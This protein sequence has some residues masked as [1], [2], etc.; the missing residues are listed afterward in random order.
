MVA[1]FDSFQRGIAVTSTVPRSPFAG[2]APEF[3]VADL[4]RRN[5]AEHGQR[6]A[7][8]AGVTTVSYDELDERTNRV[9]QAL[10]EMEGTLHARIAV[11]DKNSPAVV[12]VLIGCAKAGL[13]MVPLNWRLSPTELLAVLQDCRATVL[14]ASDEFGAHLD[15]VTTVLPELRIVAVP[16]SGKTSAPGICVDYERWI[17][18]YEPIDPG[19]TGDADDP[20]LLLY[21]SGTTGTPKGVVGTNRNLAATSR[22]A[23]QWGVDSSTVMLVAMPL[24]HIGGLSLVFITLQHGGQMLMIREVKPVQLLDTMVASRVTNAFLVPSVIA[25]LIEVDDAANRDWSMLRSITYGASPITPA[26]LLRALKTF[27]RPL[28]QVYGMT[29]TH[30]AITQLT[31]DDHDPG[32]P[33]EYLMRSAGRPYPW[34][35]LRTVDLNSGAPTPVGEPGELWVRS[36]GCTPGYFNKPIETSSAIDADGWL[37]TGDVASIDADGYLTISDRLKDMIISGGENVYPVEVEA[38]LADH[39]AVAAVA[40]IGLPDERWGEA[41]HAAVQLH[42][43]SHVEADELRQYARLH[44]AGYKC[45][46]SIEFVAS[47]PLSP[48]GK[49]LKREIRARSTKGPQ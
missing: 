38:I 32:G 16:S 17:E 7:I 29:E 4:V 37:H 22:V 30:G 36:P 25:S 40:V 6:G 23:A 41:V 21:T 13:V 42:S 27:K 1:P 48:T 19:H 24:F 47:L 20:V 3:R 11:L 43:N 45:P 31:A 8:T 28:F 9:A 26:L 46:K 14:I 34:V 44:L 15:T 18:A 12:E 2:F 10:R 39:P 5:A 33:R 49:I 35:E